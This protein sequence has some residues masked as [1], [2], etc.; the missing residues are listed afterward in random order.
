MLL[1]WLGIILSAVVAFFF[2]RNRKIEQEM[3]RARREEE[4]E[5]ILERK[6]KEIE[7]DKTLN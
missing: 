5:K 4:I 2:F 7:Q 3:E 6:R 1:L